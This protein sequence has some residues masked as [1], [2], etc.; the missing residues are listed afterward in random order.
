MLKLVD[1][2]NINWRGA[3]FW[4]VIVIGL[5]LLSMRMFPYPLIED[6]ATHPAS[7]AGKR[8]YTDGIVISA[9]RGVVVLGKYGYSIEALGYVEPGSVGHIFGAVLRYDEDR[10]VFRIE[11]INTLPRRPVKI[12][13]SLAGL[14]L[15]VVLI[16][17]LLKEARC[18]IF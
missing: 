14:I 11:K 17:G 9:D 2:A 1:I 4:G 7:F 8:I 12:I 6:L 10:R 15:A 16:A 13:I 18:R 3:I 5:F